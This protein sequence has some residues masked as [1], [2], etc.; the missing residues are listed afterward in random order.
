M[1]TKAQAILSLNPESEFVISNNEL[2][3]HSSDIK[4]PSDSEI[5]AEIN[6]LQEEYEKNSYARNRKEK[7]PNEHDLLI[8]LWEKVMEERD[9]SADVLQAIRQQVKQDNPKPE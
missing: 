5:N 1:I 3:W 6:R 8:A 7:F 4:K 9:E 2:I